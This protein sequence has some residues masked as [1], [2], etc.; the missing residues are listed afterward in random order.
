MLILLAFGLF[1][2]EVLTT[3]FGLFTAGGIIALVLCSLILFP[4]GQMFQ[5][6]PLLIATVAIIVTLLFAFVMHRIIRAHRRQAYTGKEEMIG[7][8]AIVKATLEPEG[9]V[10]FKGEHWTAVSATCRVEPGEEVIITK[11]DSLTL[12]VTKK[13]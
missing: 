8:T 13:E 10:F 9:T 4:G 12:Y 7:K 11:V 6:D 1:I 2:G 5:V 3:T